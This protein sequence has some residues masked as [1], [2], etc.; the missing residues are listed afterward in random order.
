MKTLIKLV[1]SSNGCGKKQIANLKSLKLKK[2]GD[3]NLFNFQNDS[4][5][6]AKKNSFLGRL[7]KIRHLV[8]VENF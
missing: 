3:T 7:K 8:Y 2:I 1:K 6:I 5:S 4:Q